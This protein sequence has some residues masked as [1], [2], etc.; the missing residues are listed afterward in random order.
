LSI[1]SSWCAPSQWPGTGIN[2][3]VTTNG[4]R[5]APGNHDPRRP[6]K[7][8]LLSTQDDIGITAHILPVEY[9]FASLLISTVLIIL[10]IS[11]QIRGS[12]VLY[13]QVP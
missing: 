5:P 6:V 7:L 3:S 4:C 10:L 12:A 2:I 9:I 1:A 13:H 11:S 8:T